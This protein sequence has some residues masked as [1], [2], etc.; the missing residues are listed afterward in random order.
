MRV[1]ARGFVTGLPRPGGSV[2]RFGVHVGQRPHDGVQLRPAVEA[3]Q[4]RRHEEGALDV[5]M[6][7]G[8]HH[9][10]QLQAN[11][12]VGGQPEERMK[13]LL[14]LR[15]VQVVLERRLRGVSERADRRRRRQRGR[16]LYF[17]GQACC[18]PSW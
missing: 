5:A 11:L 17:D 6:G 14:P 10:R 13:A 15:G 3:E 1:S 12:F 18:P 4:V 2:Y 7:L 8:P 16:R 9:R